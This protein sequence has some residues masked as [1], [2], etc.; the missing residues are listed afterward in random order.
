MELNYLRLKQMIPAFYS[1]AR[2]LVGRFSL[3]NFPFL[4]F[5]F[6]CQA[7]LLLDLGRQKHS[8]V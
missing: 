3:L 6:S 5:L 8:D 4:S 2:W 1:L 7:T